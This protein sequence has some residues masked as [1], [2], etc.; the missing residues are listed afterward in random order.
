MGIEIV[1]HGVVTSMME[2]TPDLF[3]EIRMKQ[4]EDTYLI[5]KASLVVET[6][7]QHFSI[8]E[9]DS[10]RYDDRW[11]VPNDPDLRSR[12]LR[13]AH[14][15][16]FSIHLSTD[17]LYQDLRRAFW[18]KGMKKDVANFVAK[19]LTCQKVKIKHR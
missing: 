10:L 6:P 14:S 5:E 4:T 3:E 8:H 15:S 13:E 19:R 2:V 12:I 18:W 7:D 1:D 17:K 11:C 16:C 9:D